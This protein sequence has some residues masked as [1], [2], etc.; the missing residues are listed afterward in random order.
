M[1]EVFFS[2]SHQDEGLRNELEKHLSL[3]RR[4]GVIDIWS[5]H[6]I[7][8]G[9]ELGGEIDQHLE[10]ADIILLLV[11]P[12]FL[13]SD[14]CYDIEMKR[15]MERHE[16]GE[17]RVIPVILRP[18]DWQSAPFGKLKAIPNDG[19]PV[20]KHQ[21]LDDAFL[22][23]T[24]AI[25]SVAQQLK[26][27]STGTVHA[28]STPIE[29]TSVPSPGQKVRSSNLR[30][31]QEFTDRQRHKFLD[32]AF[33]YIAQYFEG[34][35]AEL[36]SRNPDVETSFKRIDTTRFE[37]TAYM[38]GQERSRC[39]IWLGDSASILKGILF[40]HSGLGN[41]NSYNESLSVEDDGFSLF[42]KPM[43]MARMGQHI[44]ERLTHEGAAEYYWNIF[45]E[46]LR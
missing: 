20:T 15:A 11:S 12:D 1:V 34:S 6:R 16:H 41:G 28:E 30:I 25:R 39:G 4:Q 42:L 19:K 22:D 33:E 43:G 24:R 37:A 7:S 27:A 10:S 46:R 44:D 9:E 21:T 31:H 40:S 29:S 18:C 26:P 2:Y 5:D 32:D 23:I 17:T 45:I 38:N 36:E 3:L 35:L 8:P 14:Y 13:N